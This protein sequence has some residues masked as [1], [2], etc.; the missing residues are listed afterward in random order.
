MSAAAG[1]GNDSYAAAGVA[2]TDR[3]VRPTHEPFV[4]EKKMQ[5]HV[6]AVGHHWLARSE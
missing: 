3:G 5:L 1:P 4:E 6:R 2:Q